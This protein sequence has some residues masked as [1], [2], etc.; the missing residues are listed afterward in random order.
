M[1]ILNHVYKFLY[2]Q[3]DVITFINDF[4]KHL[5]VVLFLR[6]F[7]I[8]RLDLYHW[9]LFFGFKNKSF[10][11]VTS[12]PIFSVNSIIFLIKKWIIVYFAELQYY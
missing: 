10:K 12:S 5:I 8:S 3:I 9:K 6:Y 11:S 7:I 2:F 1:V 4:H